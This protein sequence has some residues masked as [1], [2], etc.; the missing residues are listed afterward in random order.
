ML[1]KE[2]AV[3]TLTFGD[4]AENHVGM[5]KI[6]ERVDAGAGFT[7]SDMEAAAERLQDTEII[8]LHDMVDKDVPEAH[9]MVIRNGARQMLMDSLY[10]QHD[11]WNEQIALD[12]DKKAFMY[13]RVVNKH[14]RWNLCYDTDGQEP[15]YEVRKGRIV[16]Y[17][18]VPATA[19]LQSVLANFVGVKAADLKCEGNLYYDITKCGIGW[20]GDAERRKV[21]A[22]R[23]GASLP[24]KYRWYQKHVPISGVMDI[25]LNDGDI[26][27][28]SEKAAGTDWKLSS[29]PTLRHATGCSKFTN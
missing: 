2:T 1:T 12:W 7:L 24:I 25:P 8:A 28:M 15:E 27:V 9:V 19:H 16:P 11:M 26:Y 6:G 20:H 29:I 13:G 18:D 5:Q 23:L 14:A 21:V 17:A 10:T 3:I 4:S 22:V